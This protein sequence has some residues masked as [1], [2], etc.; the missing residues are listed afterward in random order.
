MVGPLINDLLNDAGQFHELEIDDHF[1]VVP[2]LLGHPD[3]GERAGFIESLHVLGDSVRVVF[4]VGLCLDEAHDLF[5]GNVLVPLRDDVGD[6]DL[7]GRKLRSA[8][9]T[10][11]DI[12]PTMAARW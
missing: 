9:A 2:A 10:P 12:A 8:V 7:A 1:A 5:A 11:T 4:P 6:D 3:V